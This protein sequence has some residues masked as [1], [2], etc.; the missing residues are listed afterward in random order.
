EPGRRLRRGPALVPRARV[1][2]PRRVDRVSDG[3]GAARPPRGGR[4]RGRGRATRRPLP[5]RDAAR[6]RKLGRPV[7]HRHR[8]PGRLLLELPSVPAGVPGDGARPDRRHGV[9]LL[10]LVPMRI[11]ELALGRRPGW[12]VLRAG[13]GPERA[14]IAAARGLA[15]EADAVAIAGVCG[16][17]SPELRPG[18]VVAATEL[19]AEGADPVAA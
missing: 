19:R 10:V 6:G 5:R 12:R 9:T 3:V 13:M 8:L 1:A 14:R 17:V 11:E 4:R 7:L 15:V 2:R 16:A 18:D